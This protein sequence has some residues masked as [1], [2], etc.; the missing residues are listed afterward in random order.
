M[1]KL[2]RRNFQRVKVNTLGRYMLENKQ[3][4]PCQI[5]DMSPGNLA[6]TG[7]VAGQIG[8]VVIAYIDHVGRVNGKITRLFDG[9]FAMT[10]EGTKH[11][12]EKL[13]SQLTWLANRHQ[14]NLPEDRRHGREAPSN[15]FTTVTLTNGQE[16]NARILDMSL[17]GAALDFGMKVEIGTLLMVGKIRS[18]VVRVFEEGV[19]VEFA[20]VRADEPK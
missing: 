17:S 4:F 13:S 1:P 18:R 3:E 19:A 12:R 20:K 7:P 10:V 11:K 15:P 2:D 5:R 16:L 14:L 8:E 6:L 9:G